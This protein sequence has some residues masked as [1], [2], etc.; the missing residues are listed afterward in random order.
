MLLPT[1][2]GQGKQETTAPS[3]EKET[4]AATMVSMEERLSKILS[5]VAGAGNVRVL[6][7]E[8]TGVQTVYQENRD[9]TEGSQSILTRT[10]TVILSDSGHGQVGLVS[11]V[12]PPTY[13]GA[14]V[15]CQGADQSAVR[16][17]IT[18]AVANA[19]GLGYHKIT[20]LKMK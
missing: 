10:D 3:S 7:T 16:L 11:Q 12:N 18:Q 5:Q 19:T 15:L 20:V 1:G 8:A 17:A 2:T 14:I 6:L 9:A 13:L 4:A